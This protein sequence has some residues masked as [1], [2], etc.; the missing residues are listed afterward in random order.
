VRTLAGGAN[1]TLDL[2]G[3][4]IDGLGG[5]VVL[6]EGEAHRDLQPGRAGPHRRRRRDERLHLPVRQRDRRDQGQAGRLLLLF[7]PDA[8][9]YGVTPRPP[10]S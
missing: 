1:E 3:V 5:T 2:N 8:N 9:G 10:T 4:L 6:H 7:A